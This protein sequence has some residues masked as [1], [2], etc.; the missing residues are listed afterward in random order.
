MEAAMKETLKARSDVE[1]LSTGLRRGSYTHFE[2]KLHEDAR[3]AAVRWPMLTELH[4]ITKPTPEP[5]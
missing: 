1:G 3:E 4:G 2:I 5:E